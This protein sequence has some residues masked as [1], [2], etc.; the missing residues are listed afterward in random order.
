MTERNYVTKSVVF[1][2]ETN[3]MLKRMANADDRTD[4]A[5][6]RTLVREE[7]ARRYSTPQPAITITEAQAAAEVA[8]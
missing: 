5:L 6:V 1:D 4:S 7:F 8:K 2:T 3:D